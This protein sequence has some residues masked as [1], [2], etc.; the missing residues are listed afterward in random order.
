MHSHLNI[1][2][3]FLVSGGLLSPT[4]AQT[5]NPTTNT[6]TFQERKR[7]ESAPEPPAAL[8]QISVELAG[9]PAHQSP[10]GSVEFILTLKNTS[11]Q[12]VKI[13]DPLNSLRLQFTTIGDKLISLPER[14]PKGLPQV[15]LP[16]EASPG[17]KREAPYPAR[18]QFRHIMRGALA[19][20]EKEEVLT[21]PSG[22]TVQIVFESEPVV[23]EKVTE[24]LRAERGEDARKFKARAIMSLIS[25]PPTVGARSLGSDWILL[26]L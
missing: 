17:T 23:M 11:L 18:I 4:N 25:A 10:N 1:W 13:L 12:D 19:S 2:V 9:T 8:R 7:L 16:K 5:T 3:I 24:A 6:V 21:I 15:A 22:G 14:L 20:H 26:N